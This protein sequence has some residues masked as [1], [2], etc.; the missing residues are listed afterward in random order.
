MANT[1]IDPLEER[2]TE[3]LR[4]RRGSSFRRRLKRTTSDAPEVAMHVLLPKIFAGQ[5]EPVEYDSDAESVSSTDSAVT[6]ITPLEEIEDTTRITISSNDDL[7]ERFFEADRFINRDLT[8]VYSKCD[9]HRLPQINA[10]G[11][12]LSGTFH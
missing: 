5:I 2:P 11:T 1:S 9:H 4:Q 10:H 7:L 8:H 3:S 6:L 12:P